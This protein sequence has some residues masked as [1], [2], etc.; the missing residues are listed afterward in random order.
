MVKYLIKSKQKSYNNKIH[1]G[2]W[3]LK[4]DFFKLELCK[5]KKLDNPYLVNASL[6][7]FN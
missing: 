3:K 5:L 7:K 1:F 2:Y 4:V 6:A